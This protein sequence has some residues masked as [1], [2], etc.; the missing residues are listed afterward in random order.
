MGGSTHVGN[1]TRVAEGAAVGPVS[2]AEWCRGHSVAGDHESG[3]GA[4][5]SGGGVR[6]NCRHE[7]NSRRDSSAP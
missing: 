7:M 2:R 5:S 4:L 3:C 6:V 1:V